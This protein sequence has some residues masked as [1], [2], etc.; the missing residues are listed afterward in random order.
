MLPVA[1]QKINLAKYNGNQHRKIPTGKH[2]GKT[3]VKDG[4]D[5]VAEEEVDA[6]Q[7]STTDAVEDSSTA[8]LLDCV[9]EE[10]LWG[11]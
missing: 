5:P 7:A 4:Q 8:L 11:C 9:I 3:L 1:W 6:K 10:S 2:L